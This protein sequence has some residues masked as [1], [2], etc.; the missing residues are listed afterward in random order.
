MSTPVGFFVTSALAGATLAAAGLVAFPTGASREGPAAASAAAVD[1][2]L[3]VVLC[4]TAL[5]ALLELL[6]IAWQSRVWRQANVS[7]SLPATKRSLTRQ[8]W[9][10]IGRMVLTA[11][12]G[13][14]AAAYAAPPLPPTAAGP[15]RT[16]LVV[17]VL[18][19]V[20]TESVV[21]RTWFYQERPMTGV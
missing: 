13:A 6:H 15:A 4:V 21:G 8:R 12:A 5:A 11:A 19:L 16:G 9:T 18:L 3:R 1:S 20:L 7:A 14:C 10:A 17:L 2:A